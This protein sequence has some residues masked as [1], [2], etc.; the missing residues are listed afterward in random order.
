MALHKMEDLHDYVALLQHN[1][2]E[3]KSLYQDLLIN[4]TSFFRDPQAF[5][6]LKS[7]VYP[8]FIEG[9]GIT[10]GADSR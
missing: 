5:E 8:K 10:Y 4:V 1:R 9:Q 3:V 2:D 7:I 6:A